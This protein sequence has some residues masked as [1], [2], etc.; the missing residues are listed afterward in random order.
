MTQVLIALLYFF[1][2]ERMQDPY[3]EVETSKLAQESKPR[4]LKFG[5]FARSSLAQAAGWAR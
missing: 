2:E 3:E 4:F 1:S 5:K